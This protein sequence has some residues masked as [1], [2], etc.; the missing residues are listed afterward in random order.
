MQQIKKT[1]KKAISACAP[2]A[3]KRTKLSAEDARAALTDWHPCPPGTCVAENAVELDYDLQIVVP[4][5]NVE[6]Y[7]GDCLRSIAA[8]VT[9]YRCLAVIVNDGSADGTKKLCEKKHYHVINLP[10]ICTHYQICLYILL[11]GTFNS[12]YIIFRY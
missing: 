2:V 1:I 4:A 5:Y 10:V 11:L 7:I 6:K 8:Q 12:F 9:H 3:L